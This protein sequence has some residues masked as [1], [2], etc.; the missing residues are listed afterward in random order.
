MPT[1]KPVPVFHR[2]KRVK[3]VQQQ[4]LLL[5]HSKLLYPLRQQASQDIWLGIVTILIINVGLQR[6]QVLQRSCMGVKQ[7]AWIVLM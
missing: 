2:Q 5:Y 7:G 6:Q 4:F 3:P 1:Q